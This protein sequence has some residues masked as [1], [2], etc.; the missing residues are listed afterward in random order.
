MMREYIVLPFG[1]VG[2]KVGARWDGCP[3]GSVGRLGLGGRGGSMARGSRAMFLWRMSPMILS[4]GVEMPVSGSRL[5]T[6]PS[7]RRS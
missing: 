2:G 7:F 3:E 1:R 4:P 6:R 5:L